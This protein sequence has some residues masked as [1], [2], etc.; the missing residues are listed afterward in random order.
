M[1]KRI[2]CKNIPINLTLCIA[3]YNWEQFFKMQFKLWRRVKKKV[4][5]GIEDEDSVATCILI[6]ALWPIVIFKRKTSGVQEFAT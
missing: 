2:H 3:H 1:N 5:F 6:V 4:V